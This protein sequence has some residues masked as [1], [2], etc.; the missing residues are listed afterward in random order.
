MPLCLVP[1]VLNAVDVVALVRGE[2]LRVIDPHMVVALDMEA[3]V[4]LEGV[5]VDDAV[6]DDSLLDDGDQGLRSGV[7]NHLGIDLPS[8]LQD[9]EN[10]NLACSTPATLSFAPA[11]EVTLIHFDFSVEGPL[12]LLVGGN[13]SPAPSE[14]VDGRVAVHANDLCRRSRRCSGNEQLEKF[15]CLTFGELAPLELHG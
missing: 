14:E 13:G 10:G 3:V 1:E 6:G 8:A 2:R 11:T 4:A 9:A 15:T 7:G 5:A 12:P